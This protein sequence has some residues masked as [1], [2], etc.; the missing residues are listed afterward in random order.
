[1]MRTCK[2]GYGLVIL[3]LILLLTLL[4]SCARKQLVS[5]KPSVVGEERP[6]AVA[7]AP[8][9]EAPVVARP[10]EVAPAPVAPV[11]PEVMPPA[12]PP[13]PPG[14]REEVVPPRVPPKPPE[15]VARPLVPPAEAVV[16]PLKDIF[17]DFDK[18]NLKEE[19]RKA[20]DENAKWLLE[21]PGIKIQIEG[22]AD[23][24]GTDEY[25]LA[26]GERRAAAAK[27]YLKRLGV[28]EGRMT[29]ISY[30]EFRPFDPGHNEEAWAKN[31]RDH[32]VIISR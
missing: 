14:V 5:E 26:L 11:R 9:P 3:A 22:H 4:G 19:A 28:P 31:R 18:Y 2:T 13:A 17:F 10:P 1:M 20:L 15:V 32:F 23:E 25:N 12:A 21:N 6:P 29:I 30:G 8:P 24:R 16:A 27:E 7:P